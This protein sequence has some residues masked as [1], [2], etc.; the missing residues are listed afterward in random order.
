MKNW[1][2]NCEDI[3]WMELAWE[4]GQWYTFVVAVMSIWA[5]LSQCYLNLTNFVSPH[6]SPEFS[7]ADIESFHIQCAYP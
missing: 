6:G 1:E 2:I 7:F 5:I 3:N 4:S